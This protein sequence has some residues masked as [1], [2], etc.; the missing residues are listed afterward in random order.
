[1]A[2]VVGAPRGRW[3]GAEHAA[4]TVSMMKIYTDTSIAAAAAAGCTRLQHLLTAGGVRLEG[5]LQAARRGAVA[6]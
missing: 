1:M 3:G 2:G 4:Q 5:G 6:L